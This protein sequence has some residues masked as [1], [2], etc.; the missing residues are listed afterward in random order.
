MRE[1]VMGRIQ[2]SLRLVLILGVA[3]S[4]MLP[5]QS[6]EVEPKRTES[7][8][9]RIK[10]VHVES[11]EFERMRREGKI[12]VTGGGIGG[13]T[14]GSHLPPF[15]VQDLLGKAW[16]NQDLRD[17]ISL[18]AVWASWCGPCRAEMRL[19]EQLAV[20]SEKDSSI[21]VLS[22]NIDSDPEDAARFIKESESRVPV[23][24]FKTDFLKR[25]LQADSISIPRLWIFDRNGALVREA[26][27]EIESPGTWVQVTYRELVKLSEKTPVQLPK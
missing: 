26:L 21:Q 6:I 27:G 5:A 11:R 16:G 19:V 12:V 15:E 22:L 24:L 23:L 14:R 17:K 7:P 20:L 25:F 3:T 4:R 9:Q 18:I 1:T 2:S 8:A 10:F 13:A